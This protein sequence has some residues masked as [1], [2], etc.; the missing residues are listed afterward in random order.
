MSILF[1]GI[2]ANITFN[3][4]S[5]NASLIIKPNGVFEVMNGILS[6]I[7]GTFTEQLEGNCMDYSVAQIDF[8]RGFLKTILFPFRDFRTGVFICPGARY[9]RIYP[10]KEN[11][12]SIY[13]IG[14]AAYYLVFNKNLQIF[15]S[16]FSANRDSDN[17]GFLAENI[18]LNG[19]IEYDRY[20]EKG[21]FPAISQEEY[22]NLPLD[23]KKVYASYDQKTRTSI[24]GTN[25]IFITSKNPN[26][27][28]D[29]NVEVNSGYFNIK[30]ID[31]SRLAGFNKDMTYPDYISEYRYNS[32]PL[33]KIENKK[34]TE[35]N[36]GK[37]TVMF[38]TETQESGKFLVP[39]PS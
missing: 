23:W 33:I 37:A 14:N 36:D 8:I 35:L 27:T 2:Y 17:Y 4:T 22:N 19:N 31:G 7:T 29:V 11:S 9:N 26:G 38:T 1:E 24:A 32:E 25:R 20:P 10:E 28:S 13:N 3:A 5:N 15:N 16:L 12:Y 6:Y 39:F 30:E 21:L 34:L 18:T